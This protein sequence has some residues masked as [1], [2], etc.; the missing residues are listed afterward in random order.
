MTR[1]EISRAAGAYVVSRRRR[2]HQIP[3]ISGKEEKTSAAIRAELAAL[4]IPFETVGDFGLV[5]R[6]RGALPGPKL[7]L[8]ADIDALP[9]REETGLPF[10]S[11]HDGAMHACGHD[12]HIAVLL[13]VGKVLAEGKDRLRGTVLLCF[14]QAEEIG[15]GEKPILD[16]LAREGDV[17]AVLGAHLWADIP[18]GMASV[19]AGPVMAG[20]KSF[21]VAIEGCG[22]HGSRPDQGRDPINAGVTLVGDVMRLKDREISPL[23]S[24]TLSFGL[25]HAGSAT[26]VIPA[27]AELGG[28]MRF[29][30]DAERDALMSIL[31]RGCEAVAVLTGCKVE[32]TFGVGLPPVA[33]HPKA[34]AA[35][36]ASAV[37]VFGESNLIEFE[38]IMASDNF[39][40]YL[41]A[42]PGA[43]AFIGIRNEAKGAKYAHHNPRFDM[44]EDALEMAVAY[45]VDCVESWNEGV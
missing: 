12:G 3:E 26:N 18:V 24:N 13:A 41:Q 39:G 34:A 43:Y 6:V 40:C 29:F 11:L 25:F 9:L 22:C 19:R 44:D 2:F 35:C 23:A 16:Y 45:F 15:V 20:T 28:T 37:R 14:Q 32:P 30:E 42:Y 7:A 4:D 33:N 17:A 36:R 31:S 10:R 27:S 21:K 1:Q 38:K 8:R 5:A